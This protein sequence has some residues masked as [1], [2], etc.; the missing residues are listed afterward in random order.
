M[1][2]YL[3]DDRGEEGEYSGFL[4][5]HKD[6]LPPF[7]LQVFTHWAALHKA[8]ETQTPNII[9]ADMRFDETSTADLYGD[10]EA[11]ANTDRFCGNKSRAEIQIRGMQGLMICRALREHHIDVPILLFASLPPQVANHA[12]QTLAPM[13]IVEGLRIKVVRDFLNHNI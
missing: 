4:Y 1:L 5:A 2:I 6:S 3:V 8:I 10:I 13:T 9:F 12:I 11:L 7:E